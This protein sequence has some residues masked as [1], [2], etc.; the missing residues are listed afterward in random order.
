MVSF[1]MSELLYMNLHVL[2][3][4]FSNPFVLSDYFVP[5]PEMT[6]HVPSLNFKKPMAILNK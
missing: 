1:F 2:R 5:A 6:M 4:V 3:H